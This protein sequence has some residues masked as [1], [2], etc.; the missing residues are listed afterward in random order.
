VKTERFSS[1]IIKR[2]NWISDC[3]AM[4]FFQRK[5]RFGSHGD[6]TDCC[7]SHSRR[8]K[9]YIGRWIPDCNAINNQDISS[10]AITSYDFF[11]FELHGLARVCRLLLDLSGVKWTDTYAKVSCYNVK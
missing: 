7:S 4:G 9:V 6:I 10:M 8:E 3:A 1:M 2:G 5:W 11:Y